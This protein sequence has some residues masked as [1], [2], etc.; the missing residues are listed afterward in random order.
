MPTVAPWL[1]PPDFIGAMRAG[2]QAGLEQRG[3]DIGASEAADRL[4]LAYDQLASEEQ[5]RAKETQ[6]RMDLAKASL[7][8]RGH[9]MDMLGQYRQGMIANAQQ[10]MQDLADYR[11]KELE[12][13]AALAEMS[14]RN[15]HFAPNGEVIRVNDDGSVE[16]LR[17][18]DPKAKPWSF[19]DRAQYSNL[20]KQKSALQKQMG[21]FAGVDNE[22]AQNTYRQLNLQ[23]A[24]ADKGMRD[25]EAKYMQLP[26]ATAPAP[27]AGAALTSGTGTLPGPAK[28]RVP[29]R[30]PNG[31]T[32]TVE[33]DDTLPDGWQLLQQ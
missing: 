18:S 13:K 26:G 31:Q 3:Q 9:Q 33:E 27:T 14:K 30:G 6:S 16:T 20:L 29:V 12:Q 23:R 28:K 17:Q 7:A 2:A 5:Q 25:L 10:R 19:P 32:G 15:I 11:G 8:L 22:Q 4:K 24:Q 1:I 21:D